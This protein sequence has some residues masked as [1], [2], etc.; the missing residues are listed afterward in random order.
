VADW[1]GGRPLDGDSAN[2]DA[3]SGDAGNEDAGDVVAVCSV[4][5]EAPDPQAAAAIAIRTRRASSEYF[6]H[7]KTA[8]QVTRLQS[9]IVP[10]R[11]GASF[12]QRYVR[13]TAA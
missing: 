4:S 2:V 9:E 1:H 7:G 3:G 8:L 12:Y 13:I 5:L 11:L 10:R 6:T